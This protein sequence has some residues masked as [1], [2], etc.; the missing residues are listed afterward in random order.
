VK[1]L[2]L[3]DDETLRRTLASALVDG[4][5]EVIAAVDGYEAME[6]IDAQSP[7][8]LILDWEA[9]GLS[10]LEICQQVR[11]RNTRERPYIVMVTSRDETDDVVA[12]FASGVDDSVRLPYD[13]DRMRARIGAAVRLVLRDYGLVLEKVALHAALARM[14]DLP[15][16]VSICSGCRRVRDS[17]QGWEPLER[18]FS[19]QTGV[20]FSHGI[21]PDCAPKL[22]EPKRLSSFGPSHGPARPPRRDT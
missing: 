16:L 15:E 6:V 17:E 14:H 22:M 2:I 13:V 7:A 4:P 1:L 19:Q 18:F 12:A 5:L 21:C 20:Q 8:L 11:Q 9:P 3:E 10:A